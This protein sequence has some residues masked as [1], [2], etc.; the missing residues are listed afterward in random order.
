MLSP[1]LL[2][3]P[4]N[5]GVADSRIEDETFAC[6]YLQLSGDSVSRFGR[7]PCKLFVS[8]YLLEVPVKEE[9]LRFIAEQLVPEAVGESG[10]LPEGYGRSLKRSNKA[11]LPE[12]IERTKY[13][14][15]LETLGIFGIH[16][17]YM[18]QFR[19]FLEEEGGCPPTMIEELKRSIKKGDLKHWEF[20]GMKAIWFD[21]H[22]YQPLLAVD[23]KIVD[24]SPAP[25]NK[26]ERQF[27]EDLKRF[28]DGNP[29]FFNSRTLYLLRNL[30]RG[31]G[32][33]FFEAGNF[34][35]DFI[36][37]LI[38]D[39]KQRIIFVIEQRL[40]DPKV[41]LESFIV[42]NT[43][44]AAMSSQ[45]NMAKPEMQRRNI[46]FQEEDGDCYLAKVLNLELR[47]LNKTYQ[48]TIPCH[49]SIPRTLLARSSCRTVWSW[50][51]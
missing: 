18:A 39:G 31:R 6:R 1:I 21:H 45:C 20:R 28:H 34:N 50:R 42:S 40:N 25:L 2:Y 14:A 5:S 12:G 13:I 30:S 9:M 26:G 15:L 7:L 4:F 17:D 32:V 24:I 36:L 3:L 48:T 10:V 11:P 38:E 16:A 51:R 22:L 43:S 23:Q 47:T 46:L 27:V 19:D 44:S 37:W 49:Y 35:P 41:S 33:G 29:D 8:R